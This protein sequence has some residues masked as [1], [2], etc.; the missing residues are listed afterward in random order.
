MFYCCVCVFRYPEGFVCM[1][2]KVYNRNA[3]SHIFP[4]KIR[5]DVHRTNGD[6]STSGMRQLCEIFTFHV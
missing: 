5:P 1:N 6:T 4:T 2:R 3:S